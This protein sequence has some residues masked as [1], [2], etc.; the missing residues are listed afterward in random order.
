MS[1]GLEQRLLAL[2]A[3]LD[4]PDPPDVPARIAAR[5]AD[6]PRSR[7]PA[8]RT[9]VIALAAAMTLAGAAMAVPASRHAILRIFGLRGVRIERVRTLPTP[10]SPTTPRL[11][12][13]QPIALAAARHAAS[14]TALLPRGPAR[15]Y[16]AHDVPGGRISLLIGR[17]LV[18]EFRGTTLPFIFKLIGPRTHVTHVRVAGEPGLYLSGAPHQLLFENAAG[19][20]TT[21]AVRLAGNVLVWQH[22]R[23]T[24][25]IEGAGTLR[26]ALALARSLR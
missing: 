11:R 17:V 1:A 22:G 10:P 8:F 26:R 4:V 18:I 5:L 13:G 14:F 3:D 24:L 20:F 19:D 6:R 15:A 12:L 2:A 21:D 9:A 7:R 25:R 23:L 16:L